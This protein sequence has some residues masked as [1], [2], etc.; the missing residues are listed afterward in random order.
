R[1]PADGR[2]KGSD[3]SSSQEPKNTRH[4][5]ELECWTEPALDETGREQ[6]ATRIAQAQG[7][8]EPQ[9]PACPQTGCNYTYNYP[10][11]HWRAG[12]RPEGNQAPHG[13]AQRRPHHRDPFRLKQG[14]AGSCHQEIGDGGDDRESYRVPPRLLR[15][16]PSEDL[17]LD[18]S[19]ESLRNRWHYM[20][21]SI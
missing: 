20:A 13:E 19:A 5:L 11:S 21:A 14:E 12:I 18:L 4:I 16:A 10:S 9:V 6:A 17:M 2:R 7:D 8:S 15:C 1:C 3:S